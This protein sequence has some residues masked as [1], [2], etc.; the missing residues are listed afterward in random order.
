MHFERRPSGI[1]APDRRIVRFHDRDRDRN[2]DGQ[3]ARAAGGGGPALI[4][5]EDWESY[6]EGQ[7]PSTEVYTRIGAA[8]WPLV[9][10]DIGGNIMMRTTVQVFNPS[11]SVY[12]INAGADAP[13]TIDFTQYYTVDNAGNYV[14]FRVLSDTVAL[15]SNILNAYADGDFYTVQVGNS[16]SIIRRCDSEIGIANV[17][18]GDGHGAGTGA[19]SGRIRVYRDEDEHVHIAVY[20][21]T[22]LLIDYEG[23]SPPPD[24]STLLALQVSRYNSADTNHQI[25]SVVITPSDLGAPS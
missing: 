12:Q 18:S 7:N 23:T 24:L 13:F 1:W 8:S 25:D 19:K 22:T 17:D 16:T 15:S 6:T 4:L 9:A 5:S 2:R 14:I 20:S 11:H 10:I 21:G 3:G